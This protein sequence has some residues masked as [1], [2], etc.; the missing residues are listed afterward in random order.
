MNVIRLRGVALYT[1]IRSRLM[2]VGG[3]KLYFQAKL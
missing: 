2:M 1:R 3:I